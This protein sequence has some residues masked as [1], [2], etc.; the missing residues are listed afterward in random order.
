VPTF[1]ACLAKPVLTFLVVLAYIDDTFFL[2]K[3]AYID[4]DGGSCDV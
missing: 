1:L 4:I 2:K 3:R